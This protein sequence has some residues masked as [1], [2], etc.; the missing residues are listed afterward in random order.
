M[1][2][3]SEILSL[4]QKLFTECEKGYNFHS[5]IVTKCNKYIGDIEHELELGNY[6]RDGLAKLA[7]ELRDVRRERRKS[8]DIVE[9]LEPIVEFIGEAQNKKVINKMANLIGDIRKKE[10]YH[11]NRFY[12]SRVRGKEE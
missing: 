7:R 2:K 6:N 9:E 4:A 10:D 1:Y 11:Q 3:N 12:V 8:K 5:E